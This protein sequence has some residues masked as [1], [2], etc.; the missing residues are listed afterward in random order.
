MNMT[1]RRSLIKAGVG[2]IGAFAACPAWSNIKTEKIFDSIV[3]GGGY[4][5]II[6]ARDMLN[7]GLNVLVLESSQRPRNSVEWFHP[8]QKNVAKELIFYGLTLSEEKQCNFELSSSLAEIMEGYDKP[9]SKELESYLYAL[10]KIYC[11]K[12]TVDDLRHLYSLMNEDHESMARVVGVYKVKENVTTLYREIVSNI[13]DNIEYGSS[14]SNIGIKD[15]GLVLETDGKHIKTRSVVVATPINITNK[16]LNMN[17]DH[18]PY[19]LPFIEKAN[20]CFASQWRGFIDGAI[21]S[22]VKAAQ[23]TISKL[24]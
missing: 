16:L 10:E 7:A 5:G 23:S 21:D 9:V 20:T 19:V 6:A 12:V 3:V 1:T 8:M 13:G 18:L 15:N 2:A 24:I 17:S 14:V 11:R 22:G 4:A